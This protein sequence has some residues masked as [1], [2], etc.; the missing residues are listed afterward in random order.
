MRI[1]RAHAD[2]GSVTRWDL[3]E[4][5]WE[6]VY[7]ASGLA[8]R[9]ADH[10]LMLAEPTDAK[11]GQRKRHA[12]LMFETFGAPAVYC[13]REA[14]LSAFSCGRSRALVLQ[15][16]GSGAVVAPVHEGYVLTRGVARSTLGGR[17]LT[18]RLLWQLEARARA[19]H[20][21]C[22]AANGPGGYVRPPV[23]ARFEAKRSRTRE[24]S[25]RLEW[26]ASTG[27]HP[28]FRTTMR[29]AVAR[30]V[31][32]DVCRCRALGVPPRP[33]KLE[34]PDGT[35]LALS[36]EE[37]SAVPELLF[38]PDRATD[39]DGPDGAGRAPPLEGAVPLHHL[40]HNAVAGADADIR[41]E[42]LRTILLAGGGA[43]MPDLRKRVVSETQQMLPSAFRVSVLAP[44][45]LGRRFSAFIGGSILAS[46]GSFHQ[47]WVGKQ[48]YEE[49]GGALLH[50][51]CH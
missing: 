2:D 19:V 28:T 27:T 51:R 1:E 49:S 32:E 25:W 29:L 39:L 15:L 44:G 20:A 6:H 41:A 38:G 7:G 33:A 3:V 40:L 47:M 4:K 35:A 31:K 8:L 14:L 22:G 13:A 23:P 10:P 42:L 18:R 48:E 37:A 9:A 50:D 34:L 26:D 12:E 30:A 36:S 17:E 11:P 21:A 24:G 43:L 45:T 16:G 46:L 5:M